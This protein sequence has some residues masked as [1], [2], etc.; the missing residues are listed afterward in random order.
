MSTPTPVTTASRTPR[1]LAEAS[2]LTRSPQFAGNTGGRFGAHGGA[3]LP[4][5]LVGPMAEVAAAYEEARHDEAFFAE[6]SRLLRDYVGRPS[7]I[8]AADRLSD[9]LGGARILLK[10]EDLNHTG[11]HKINHTIGEALLAK[12]MGKRT[13]IAETGAGQHG[14]ALAT[15]AALVGL[16]CEIHMGAVDVAKQ[17]PNVVRMRLLGAKAV[18][19]EVGQ[20]TLKEAVDSAFGVYAA[21]PEQ[22]LFAIGSVVGPAPFP[23]MVR[24]FQS[25]VGRESRAQLLEDLGRLPDAVIAS[26]G[27]GSNAMGA[28]TAYLEDED[29]RLIGVEPGGTGDEPGAHAATMTFGTPGTLHG[30]DTRVLQD[31]DGQPGEVHSIASGLDYP[32]VGPQHVHLHELGRVEYVREGDAAVLDA[33]QRLSRTEGIIPAL[34]SAHALAHAIRIAPALPREA[35]LLVNLSGRGDKDIDYVAEKIG[36][37]GEADEIAR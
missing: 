18:S 5:P 9:S 25:V 6:Y 3:I 28:F 33:F 23:D 20:R 4:P 14:V 31:A 12:R 34:E 15:A 32:G 26:V 37:T 35:A 13:L 19:V 1:T 11:A 29:V 36:M 8:S 30:M 17:R 2:G 7:P 10:R 24:D 22:Y 16:G 21:D 27:G